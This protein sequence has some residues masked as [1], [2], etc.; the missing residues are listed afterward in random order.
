MSETD[1]SVFLKVD[2]KYRVLENDLAF[3]LNDINP[4]SKGHMLFIPKRQFSCFFECTDAEL[5]ALYDLIKGAK[6]LL[7]EEH[8]PDGYNVGVNIG[9]VA[10]Q[11]VF[12]AHIHLIPRYKDESLEDT[13]HVKGI[14]KT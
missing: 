10:G 3:A 4:V 5:I 2:P 7:D 9:P 12:H 8:H 14:V 1:V 6:K 13:K 11:T